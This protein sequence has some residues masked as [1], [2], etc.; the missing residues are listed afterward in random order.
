MLCRA[1]GAPPGTDPAFFCLSAVVC[2]R[3]QIALLEETAGQQKEKLT[4]LAKETLRLGAA[5][6]EEQRA[7]AAAAAAAKEST[8]ATAAEAEQARREAAEVA[9]AAKAAEHELR[10][11]LDRER[12]Q[13]SAGAHPAS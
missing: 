5:L 3:S 7:R 10:T 9:A 12:A 6:V 8:S 2:C 13:A 11:T 1:C 4:E